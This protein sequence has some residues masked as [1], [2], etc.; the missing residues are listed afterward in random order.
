MTAYSFTYQQLPDRAASI[1]SFDTSVE[2]AQHHIM[3]FD[4][5][6]KYFGLDRKA[7]A[8]LLS[9]FLLKQDLARVEIIV[10]DADFIEK[11]CPRLVPVI[12]RFA[13]RFTVRVTEEGIRHFARG[14]AIFDDKAVIRRPHFD[15]ST[16][17]WDTDEHAIGLA[18]ELMEQLRRQSTAA[19]QQATGL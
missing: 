8:E 18:K 3:I 15:R 10:H 2:A 19:L 5:D 9:V 17:Y 4:R 13:P 16:S 11:H 14:F 6:G 7:A 12:R 1:S